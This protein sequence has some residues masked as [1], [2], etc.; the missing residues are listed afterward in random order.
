ML[1]KSRRRG[2]MAMAGVTAKYKVARKR[3][4]HQV[5]RKAAREHGGEQ[6]PQE[7][8]RHQPGSSSSSKYCVGQGEIGAAPVET[9]E[10]DPAGF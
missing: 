9:G 6:G 1:A 5:A 10:D 2:V 3:V 4:V 7:R 8:P